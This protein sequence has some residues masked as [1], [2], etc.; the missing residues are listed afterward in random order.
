M[1]LMEPFFVGPLAVW[2]HVPKKEH[3]KARV[4]LIHGLSEHSGRH[5]NTIQHLIGSGIEVVRFDLRGSG[6]SGGRRQ[7]VERFDDYVQDV[8]HTFHWIEENLAPLPLYVLGHSLGGAIAIY[9]AAFYPKD[10]SGLVLSAPAFLVGSGISSVKILIAKLLERFAPTLKIPGSTDFTAISRDENVRTDYRE[11]PLCNHF[12]TLQQG[13]EILRALPG[14]PDQCRRIRVPTLIVHGSMD[15]LVKLEG[16]FQILE[17]LASQDKMLQVIPGG[18][19]E[20]HNDLC[21]EEYF[22]ILD[23]WFKTRL[24]DDTRA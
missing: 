11:D 3:P 21:K 14:I 2:T 6:R 23:A 22:A 15:Q 5:L 8:A 17:A 13:N 24:N 1:M 9:Y 10:C 18:F 4:L 7:W 20:P 12:N 19:H 16:S